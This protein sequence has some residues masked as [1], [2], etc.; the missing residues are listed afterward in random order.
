MAD[1]MN[2][3]GHGQALALAGLNPSGDDGDDNPQRPRGKQGG[4]SGHYTEKPRRAMGGY[5]VMSDSDDSDAAMPEQVQELQI[6]CKPCLRK[7]SLKLEISR[8]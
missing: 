3:L 8:S 4:P 1:V 2:G 5:A 7:G 6:E